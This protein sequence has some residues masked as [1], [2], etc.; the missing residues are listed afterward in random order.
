MV[1]YYYDPQIVSIF[2]QTQMDFRLSEM[3][4]LQELQ[5]QFLFEKQLCTLVLKILSVFASLREIELNS[6]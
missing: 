2:N 6:K 4:F 5:H 3:S 1:N